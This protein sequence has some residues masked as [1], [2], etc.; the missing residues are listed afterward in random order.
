MF[1][2]SIRYLFVV[3]LILLASGMPGWATVDNHGT[4]GIFFAQLFDDNRLPSHRGPLVVLKVLEESP[5]AKAGIHSGDFVVAVNGVPVPG[6]EIATI[7]S[8]EIHGPIGATL[9]LTVMKPDGS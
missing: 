4:V 6:R 7:L 2:Q 5:A 9:R 8:K 1:L 3:S